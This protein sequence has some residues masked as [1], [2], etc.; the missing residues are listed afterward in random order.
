MLPIVPAALSSPPRRRF[1]RPFL[2]RGE[3]L[4]ALVLL[5][6]VGAVLW[7]PLLHYLDRARLDSALT[8]AHLLNQLLPQYALDNDDAYPI[9]QGTSAVGTS[10]GI[11]RS[12]LA[13]RYASDP[14]VFVLTSPAHHPGADDFS[15]FTG[16]HIDWDFTAGAT[17]ATPLT[18]AAPAKLPVFYCTGEV[19]SYEMSPGLPLSGR[20]PFERK[21]IVVAYKEGTVVYIE[22]AGKGDQA[23]APGFMPKGLVAPGPYTQIKPS[24]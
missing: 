18:S 17:A 15:D 5:F 13:D 3:A 7:I 12:L 19:V 8:K 22:A 6:L 23:L 10:E 24:R 1:F 14:A 9:G 16:A 20:G 21:G 2:N 4:T 11:A